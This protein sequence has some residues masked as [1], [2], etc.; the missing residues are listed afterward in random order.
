MYVFQ[1]ALGTEHK[2]QKCQMFF[3]TVK[4]LLYVKLHYPRSQPK[5]W[6]LNKGILS[7]A[8]VMYEK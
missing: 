5:L 6:I 8:R 3:F 7:L 2:N 4:C 1:S